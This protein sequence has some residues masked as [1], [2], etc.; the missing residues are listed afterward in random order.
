[1]AKKLTSVLASDSVGRSS[2]IPS[3]RLR[4]QVRASAKGRY[5]PLAASPSC[6]SPRRLSGSARSVGNWVRFRRRWPAVIG[7]VLSG[8]PSANWVRFSRC[9]LRMGRDAL[10][11]RQNPRIA[12]SSQF[13]QWFVFRCHGQSLAEGGSTSYTGR[14][15]V[16][17]SF[18]PLR[19]QNRHEIDRS[20]S[21]IGEPCPRPRGLGGDVPRG[22]P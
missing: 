15:T 22:R 4:D 18:S 1:M 6:S 13:E 10:V 9:A 19:G 14:S 2:G 7:F 21:R 8:R 3:Q 11:L 16:R 17:P 5:R 20:T 12:Q